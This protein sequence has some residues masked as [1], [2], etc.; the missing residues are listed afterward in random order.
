MRTAAEVAKAVH[1]DVSGRDKVLAPGP[2][3]SPRDRSLSILLSSTAPDGFIV[4][5]FA[6]DDWRVCRDHVRRCLGIVG[7]RDDDR[8][9]FDRGRRRL[10]PREIVWESPVDENRRL[11]PDP[12]ALGVWRP[13][14]PIA[15]TL[16]ELY[17]TEHRKL[18]APFPP[19]MRFAHAP[20]RLVG[21][22]LPALVAAVQ[23]PDRRVVAAQA[24]F[25][26]LA[27]GA[28]ANVSVPRW[29]FGKLGA[30]AVRLAAAGPVLGI[31]EGTETAL[32]AMQLSGLPCWAV[33]GAERLA[34][35]WLPPEATEVHIFADNDEAGRRGA[36]K[37]AER[38]IRDG[39]R[40]IIRTPAEEFGDWA[41]LVADLAREDA[42]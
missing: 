34:S 31:A 17:L 40:V 11:E 5:S 23:A 18:R 12:Q 32:A 2:G 19:T 4:D 24:T 42:D 30:G 28:K 9:A 41:D 14:A 38:H 35:V 29:T 21:M 16:A 7:S 27:T 22:N 36:D 8:R 20:C 26:N 37:A 33:L 10:A 15:G 6:G 39:R 13:A 25:L 3:H 1:G